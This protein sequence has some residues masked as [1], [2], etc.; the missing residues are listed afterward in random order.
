MV[1]YF[2]H[3]LS[4]NYIDLS[5][6]YVDSSVIYVDLSDHYVD[7]SD[8]D[9]DL[10]DNDVDLSDMMST[11]QI[12]FLHLYGSNWAGTRFKIYFLTNE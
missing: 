9:V 12:I 7:L 10:S 4:D 1:D 2:C 11:S 5:N 8:N 6:L 3:Y